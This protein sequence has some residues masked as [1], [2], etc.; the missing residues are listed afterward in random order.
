MAKFWLLKVYIVCNSAKGI[1][2]TRLMERGAMQ[3]IDHS[4][5]F[6]FCVFLYSF[7][8]LLYYFIYILTGRRQSV[9][10]TIPIARHRLAKQIRTAVDGL[11][12]TAALCTARVSGAFPFFPSNVIICLEFSFFSGSALC[13]FCF[14]FF[15][16]YRG[17]GPLQYMYSIVLL[18][19]KRF[20]SREN[21]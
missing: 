15:F 12:R 9:A 16:T 4:T 13:V 18:W 19:S 10:C 17:T 5:D 21:I 3:Q 14:S 20:K 11:Y 6:L 2:T 1:R 7:Y 8:V